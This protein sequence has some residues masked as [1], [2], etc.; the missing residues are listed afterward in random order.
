M[1]K[2]SGM[3]GNRS[4]NADGRL[5]TVRSDKHLQANSPTIQQTSCFRTWRY[6]SWYYS[7]ADR[8]ERDKTDKRLDYSPSF[9][10]RWL[11]K[12]IDVTCLFFGDLA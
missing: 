12:R 11:L 3:R 9:D 10:I 6:S 1:G 5:R 4:R 2:S 7:E 8:Q